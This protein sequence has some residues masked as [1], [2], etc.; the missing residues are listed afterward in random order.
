MLVDGMDIKSGRDIW[1][2][3]G[4]FRRQ[5]F[6]EGIGTLGWELKRLKL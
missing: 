2:G 6:P 3:S 4:I 1:E 5:N